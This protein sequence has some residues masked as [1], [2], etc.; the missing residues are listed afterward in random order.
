MM[1]S[2]QID[3][4]LATLDEWSQATGD[5]SDGSPSLVD[6]IPS[7]S[8]MMREL[9]DQMQKLADNPASSAEARAHISAVL[10]G[11]ASLAGLLASDDLPA[12]RQGPVPDD[13]REMIQAIREGE[14]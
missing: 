10:R 4:A 5:I 14:S 12:P 3:E 8:R 6:S 11:E 7:S 2:Q 1:T 9:R 13:M